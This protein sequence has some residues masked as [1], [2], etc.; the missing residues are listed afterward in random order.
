MNGMS[1]GVVVVM[2]HGHSVANERGVINSSPATATRPEWGLTGLGAQQA[3]RCELPAL[4]TGASAVVVCTS[5]FTRAVET[6][7]IVIERLGALGVTVTKLVEMDLRERNFGPLL[8][9]EPTSRYE[10]VWQ[11][12]KLGTDFEGAENVNAVRE[13]ALGV[14]RRI[15]STHP[16]CPIVV[17]SHGDVLQILQ[18]AFVNFPAT[19]HR[20]VQHLENAQPRIVQQPS[21]RTA[22][23]SAAET[24]A[25]LSILPPPIVKLTT[26]QELATGRWVKFFKTSYVDENDS[27]TIR[28]CEHFDRTNRPPVSDGVDI[29]PIIKQRGKPNSLLLVTQY[30]PPVGT[31]S[32]E[33]PAGLVDKGETP[34]QAALREL[35]EE[36]GFQGKIISE[37]P[38]IFY[39]VSITSDNGILFVVEVDVDDEVNQSPKQ[40]LDDGEHIHILI[41]PIGQLSSTM[42]EFSRKGYV[43]DSKVQAVCMGLQWSLS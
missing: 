8:E 5:D 41:I 35:K 15:E 17:V 29:L 32:L 1:G 16:G 43:I 34:A 33:F 18:T 9:G 6:A 31:H 12:D 24:P 28:E 40:H 27:A 25:C 11:K 22:A 21:P 42:E 26:S 38:V 23:L 36:T 30:R 2:R 3:S 19:Q 37:S 7:D 13:R 20:S 10:E 39:D 4:L 14:L